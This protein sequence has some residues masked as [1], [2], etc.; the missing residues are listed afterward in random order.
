[1]AHM[2]ILIVDDDAG[3]R[4]ILGEMLKRAGYRVSEAQDGA[5]ALHHIAHQTFD[6]VTMDLVMGRMD[7]VDAISVLMNETTAPILVISAHLTEQNR[8]ELADRGVTHWLDKPFT[9]AGLLS[10]VSA[11]VPSSDPKQ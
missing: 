11:I 9:Q 4:R 3:V 1:M 2:H 7:G 10:M 5:E 8:Q 6:L